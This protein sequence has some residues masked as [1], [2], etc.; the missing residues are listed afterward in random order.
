MVKKAD[1]VGIASGMPGT[2]GG[3]TMAT[4]ASSDVPPGTRLYISPQ[5]AVFS[6][7]FYKWYEKRYG[8][9]DRT[10]VLAHAQMADAHEVWNAAIASVVTKSARVDRGALQVA[11]NMLKRD[12]E[13]GRFVRGELAEEL[14]RSV[15]GD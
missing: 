6:E 7:D 10:D 2:E 1:F 9:V 13:E 11:I 4:F 15:T 3:F 8:K 14:A 12:A 5:R